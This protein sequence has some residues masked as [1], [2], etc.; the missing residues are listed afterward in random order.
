MSPALFLVNQRAR[1]TLPAGVYIDN[2]LLAGGRMNPLLSGLSPSTRE[3]DVKA[4]P[5]K[6]VQK[7]AASQPK[8]KETMEKQTEASRRAEPADRGAK[9]AAPQNTRARDNASRASASDPPQDATHESAKLD[10]NAAS[11]NGA[12]PVEA[13]KGSNGK[14][15][16]NVDGDTE[17][18][19][20]I[21]DTPVL[22]QLTTATTGIVALADS[23]EMALVIDANSASVAP[24]AQDLT[25]ALT[26]V[27]TDAPI[28]ASAGAALTTEASAL[29]NV[30]AEGKPLA[31]V[32]IGLPMSATGVL[33]TNDGAVP[34]EAVVSQLVASKGTT[35][36]ALAGSVSNPLNAMSRDAESRFLSAFTGEA[37]PDAAATEGTSKVNSAMDMSSLLGGVNKM[38]STVTAQ[39]TLQSTLP[40]VSEGQLRFDEHMLLNASTPGE[41]RAA[42]S[43]AALAA[44]GLSPAGL[45]NVAEA[46]VQMPV[47]ISFGETGWGTM[48]AERSA[49]MASKSI[50]FAELQLDP[51]ELGPLQVKVSVNQ[52]QASVSFVAANAQVKDALDQSLAKLRELLEEQGLDL[53]NVDVSDQSSQQSDPEAE[54]EGQGAA[55]SDSEHDE[56]NMVAPTTL[57]GSVSYGVDHY[58]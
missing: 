43:A 11:A 34:A 53:V 26:S 38:P 57:Q 51:P 27:L 5:V 4:S 36:Q 56:S 20:E 33:A 28:Q 18:S 8:F 17:K 31:A 25:E 41:E 13:N 29:T 40:L 7:E 58:A 23:D 47:S 24:Q 19:V 50:K 1:Q 14:T 44:F 16:A 2:T 39:T 12:A 42:P 52:E 22:E 15:V 32:G 9:N 30:D 54:R 37:V 35:G 55:M 10:D 49:M 45:P 46:R 6:P 3:L 21:T 48:I